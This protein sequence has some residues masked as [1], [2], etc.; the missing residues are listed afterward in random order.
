MS[1]SA[2]TLIIKQP[3]VMQVSEF[4][5]APEPVIIMAYY[6]IGNIV[7]AG[8]TD[9]E[10]YVSAFGQ[11]LDGLSHLHAKGVVHRD[12][13]PENFLVEKKPFFRVVITDFGLAKVAT[14]TTLL[15]T[16][17]GTLMYLAPEVFPGLSDGHGPP[18]DIWSLGVITFKWLYGI[19]KTPTLPTPKKHEK[20]VR[21]ERWHQWINTWSEWLLVK[22]EDEDDNQVVEILLGMIEVQVRKRWHA[23]RCLEQGFENGLFKRRTVDGLVVCAKD[24]DDLILP[25]EEQDSGTK[26]AT[27]ASPSAV[28]PSLAAAS[29]QHTQT[30]IDP[31]ATI[32]LGTL[33]Q[34]GSPAHSLSAGFEGSF[35]GPPTSA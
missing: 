25:T 22:L 26:T 3:N 24:A 2:M 34:G 1:A 12:L 6:S 15:T 13:K 7:D 21:P 27:A 32:I 19:P 30:G 10:T 4:Q 29:L 14:S 17:C 33:W 18:V 28:E 35:P 8:I 16:F 9:E 11:I 31:E 23:N 20:K 5:E